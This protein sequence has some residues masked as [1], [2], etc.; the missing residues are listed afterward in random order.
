MITMN[1]AHNFTLQLNKTYPVKKERV[2]NAWT[3]PEELEKWWGPEGMTTT[4][5]EMNV[6]V[7]GKYKFNMHAPNGAT[8]VL[9]GEYLEIV[10]N[11]KLVYTWKWENG[12]DDFP[13]T[14]VTIE[15]LEKG[16]STAVVVTHTELPS[17]EEAK[18]HN[19]GWTSSLESSLKAYLV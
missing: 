8:H 13:A 6:E 19:H 4:I 18:N 17:E 3:K 15:F 2:F 7:N 11:E 9:T 16:N 12:N 10:S 5:D 1:N 14:K